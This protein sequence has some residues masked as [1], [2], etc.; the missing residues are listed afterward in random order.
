M[1]LTTNQSRRY[2]LEKLALGIPLTALG[3]SRLGMVPE[4]GATTTDDV[5]LLKSYID[6]ATPFPAVHGAFALKTKTSP[7]LGGYINDDQMQLGYNLDGNMPLEPY[8]GFYQEVDY[9]IQVRSVSNIRTMETYIEFKGRGSGSLSLYSRPWFWSYVP[10]TSTDRGGTTGDGFINYGYLLTGPHL[11]TAAGG[12]GLKIIKGSGGTD[13]VLDAVS[14]CFDMEGCKLNNLQ[15]FKDGSLTMSGVTQGPNM[16][17]TTDR[18]HGY[19]VGTTVGFY[20][21]GTGVFNV[22]SGTYDHLIITDE[23]TVISVQSPTQFTTD[24]TNNGSIFNNA[25]CKQIAPP[26]YTAAIKQLG[27]GGKTILVNNTNALDVA[28]TSRFT[29]QVS[30]FNLPTFATERDA[31]TGGLQSGSIYMT[32]TGELRIKL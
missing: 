19:G 7:Y 16:Q 23:I 26:N 15:V 25:T 30:L 21:Y 22:N 6:L 5:T 4:A 32:A 24:Y 27:L 10:E 2:L 1:G 12:G 17:I 28:G 11:G 18:P 20:A 29:G 31:V 3:L 13:P 8:S 14:A 9:P